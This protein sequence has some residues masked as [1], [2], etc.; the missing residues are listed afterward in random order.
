[1]KRKIEL[2]DVLLSCPGDAYEA[3]FGAV[4][5]AISRFNDRAEQCRGI[6]LNLLHWSGDSFPQAGKPAQQ[7]LNAQIVDKADMAI[8]IFWTR[9]GTP[10]DGYGSGTE[11]EIARLIK[12]EKQVFLYFLEKAP[13][14]LIAERPEFSKE[15]QKIRNFRDGYRGLYSV[16]QDESKLEEKLTSDLDKYFDSSEQ[17]SPSTEPK[18]EARW[19]RADTKEVV[20]RDQ[21][22]RYGNITA[23]IDGSVGRMQVALPD[24][25]TV[26]SEYDIE[27]KQLGNI[28]AEGFPQE[29]KVSVPPQIVITKKDF[30]LK[31][32]GNMYRAELYQ[33]KFGGH[34]L[35]LYDLA[36]NKLQSFE[37]K[38]P[39]G[40]IAHVDP[41][42]K[43]VIFVDKSECPV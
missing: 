4:R 38:A 3:C 40:M 12:S 9:F 10:T 28:V 25:K 16:V 14:L 29:Y 41:K 27:K 43:R 21:L 13:P 20:K 42:S 23:Q 8:A 24:G 1:M 36:E 30:S 19:F 7:L 17:K 15:R 39:A 11:E 6:R 37:A 5:N 35:A 32:E 2:Y 26:Y 31:L 34:L 22:I 33:L 18:G